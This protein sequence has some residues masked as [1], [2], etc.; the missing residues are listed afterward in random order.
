MSGPSYS[1]HSLLLKLPNKGMSFPFPPLKL[2]NMGREEYSK[3]ILIIHFH[4]ISFPPPKRKV[5]VWSELGLCWAIKFYYNILLWFFYV[6]FLGLLIFLG[7]CNCMFCH[8]GILNSFFFDCF[9]VICVFK[10][11]FVFGSGFFFVFLLFLILFFLF[12]FR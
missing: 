12:L 8:F 9:C 6:W 11:E 4:S 10:V 7:L 5:R 3:I 2:P 1:F